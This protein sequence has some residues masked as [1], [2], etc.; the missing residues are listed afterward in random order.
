MPYSVLPYNTLYCF[1]E[2]NAPGE[3]NAQAPTHTHTQTDTQQCYNAHVFYITIRQN[4]NVNLL[5]QTKKAS[6]LAL[7]HYTKQLK[8]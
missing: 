5:C 3:L 8:A 1:S 7:S 2:N 6:D 4:D